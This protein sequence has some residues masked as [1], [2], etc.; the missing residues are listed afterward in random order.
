MMLSAW[1]FFSWFLLRGASA[2][3]PSVL[4]R[5]YALIWLFAGSFAL[6]A[7]VTVLA[8]NYQ[9]AGGYW[10]LFYFAAVFFALVV[11]YI[12]LFFVPKKSAFVGG[13]DDSDGGRPNSGS[14]PLTATTTGAQSDD[15]PAEA[16]D[17]TETTSLLRGDRRSFRRYDGRR[18]SASDA[19]EHDEHVGPP[20]LGHPY[21]GEQEWSGKLPGWLWVL[22]FLLLVPIV[23]TLVGQIALLVT[24][25]LYQTP[26]DGSSTFFIYVAFAA[27][28]TLLVAPVGPFVHRFTYHV[29]TFLFFVCVGTVI[30]N[31]VA[32]PFSREHRLKVY[33]GQQVDLDTGINMVS[34]TALD[35]YVQELV[36]ELPS[37]QGRAVNCSTPDVVARKELTKCAWEGLPAQVVPKVSPFSNKTRPASWLDYST[38]RGARANEASIRVVGQNTRA[39]RIAFDTPIVGLTVA[40][41]VSDDPRFNATG[42]NGSREVRLWHR[43]WSQPWNVSVRWDHDVA[44]NSTLSGRVICLWSDA[45]AGAIPAFDEVQHYLPVWAIATKF[46]DGLVEG[47]KRFKL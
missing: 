8:N 13:F 34:L 27:L 35:G 15:H 22:Q 26:A 41:A 2:M 33:F 9:I 21:P 30:Y 12:E 42:D 29:P 4:Q 17:V 43:E 47:S 3:R 18:Q 11:S 24:S 39:C 10:A 23:I 19:T 45:N 37:A 7:F 6:L 16:D 14:R 20:D 31:L 5:M 28:A 44:S 25:A 38:T 32:F 36:K 46:G 1:F 40:G